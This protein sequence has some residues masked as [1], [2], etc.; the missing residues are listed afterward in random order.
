MKNIDFVQIASREYLT[1]QLPSGWEQLPDKEVDAFISAHLIATFD[2]WE[3]EGLW[4]LITNHAT[5]LESMYALGRSDERTLSQP[6]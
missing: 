1:D 3:P 5:S 4:E 2:Y 6:R